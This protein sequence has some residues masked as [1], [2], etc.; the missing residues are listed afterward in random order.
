MKLGGVAP[1]I[2]ISMTAPRP[3][4]FGAAWHALSV[5][6][7]VVIVAALWLLVTYPRGVLVVLAAWLAYR[8]G[9]L[10]WHAFRNDARWFAR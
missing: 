3:T 2:V 5:A 1:V 7:I 9:R 4:L 8:I 6:G 10:T